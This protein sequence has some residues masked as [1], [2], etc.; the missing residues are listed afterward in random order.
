MTSSLQLAILKS[1]IHARFQR[2][3]C[4]VRRLGLMPGTFW[5]T[6]SNNKKP[7]VIWGRNS[8]FHDP[9]REPVSPSYQD[10]QTPDSCSM[11]QSAWLENPMGKIWENLR[12]VRGQF[13]EKT[14]KRRA[15]E[16]SDSPLR[17]PRHPPAGYHWI[18]KDQ[19]K[20]L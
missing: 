10:T 3:I 11:A 15:P 9:F 2:W 19:P 5:M 18:A 6:P 12:C 20:G 7:S 13:F 4:G 8:P 14:A 17:R 1:Y 16:G